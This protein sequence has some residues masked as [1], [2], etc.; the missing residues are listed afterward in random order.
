MVKMWVVALGSCPGNG[1]S[2]PK[3]ERKK[4]KTS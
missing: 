2:S 1:V 4:E 3:K